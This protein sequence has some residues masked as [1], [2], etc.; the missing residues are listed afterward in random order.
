MNEVNA[1]DP[2]VFIQSRGIYRAVFPNITTELLH[3]LMFNTFPGSYYSIS[4]PLTE[5]ITSEV[6]VIHG[7]RE[8]PKE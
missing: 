8:I 2:S 5:L 3:N 6:N 7:V 4:K 1:L